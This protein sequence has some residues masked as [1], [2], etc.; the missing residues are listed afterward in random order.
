MIGRKEN[1]NFV[2]Q[3]LS[4]LS[5]RMFIIEKAVSSEL[6]NVAESFKKSMDKNLS[7]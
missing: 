5:Q 2:N 4:A 6:G 3:R 7:T 1:F